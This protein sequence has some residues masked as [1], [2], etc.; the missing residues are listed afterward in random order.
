MDLG[1]DYSREL[2]LRNTVIKHNNFMSITER[3]EECHDFTKKTGTSTYLLI[4]GDPGVGKSTLLRNYEAR[5]P[6]TGNGRTISVPVLSVEIPPSPSLV[7]LVN[8]FLAAYGDV[9]VQ[10]S[11][12]NV[13]DMTRQ[14]ITLMKAAGTVVILLDEI[15]NFMTQAN[16]TQVRALAAWLKTLMNQLSIALIAAGVPESQ[17]LV[18]ADDQLRSRMS[19]EMWIKP[20]DIDDKEGFDVFRKILFSIEKNIE[21]PAPSELY[22]NPLAERLYF[23]CDGRLRPLISLLSYAIRMVEKRGGDCITVDVLYEAFLQTF[24]SDTPD[25]DNPFSNTFIARRLVGL[26]EAHGPRATA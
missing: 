15:Q 24:K 7:S 18:N 9:Y 14:L 20:F 1:H 22:N 11:R 2:R 8:A 19:A 3:M 4:L 26:G 21:F 23:A 5:H 6:R 10:R 17:R 13:G 16:Q 25:R 12:K